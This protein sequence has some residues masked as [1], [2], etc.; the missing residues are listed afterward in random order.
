M[1]LTYENDLASPLE[2]GNVDGMQEFMIDDERPL[3]TDWDIAVEN[4]PHEGYDGPLPHPGL[5]APSKPALNDR[6]VVNRPL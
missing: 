4:P 5:G 6:N 2:S 1:P 3:S